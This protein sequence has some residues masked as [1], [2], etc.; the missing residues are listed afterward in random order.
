M[1]K[2]RIIFEVYLFFW[3]CNF[4]LHLQIHFRHWIILR[5]HCYFL[6]LWLLIFKKH[7]WTTFLNFPQCFFSF[8]ISFLLFWCR[9]LVYLSYCIFFWCTTF[10]KSLGFVS[11][12]SHLFFYL[13]LELACCVFLSV[14]GQP[15]VFSLWIYLSACLFLDSFKL[16]TLWAGSLQKMAAWINSSLLQEG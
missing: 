8:K 12:V 15:E 7:T 11:V 6:T 4:L 9:N 3:L 16:L 10:V 1:I 13:W 14:C 2:Y 5:I